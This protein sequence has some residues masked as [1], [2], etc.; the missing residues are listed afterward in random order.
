[1][2][3]KAQSARPQCWQ[4]LSPANRGIFPHQSDIGNNSRFTLRL[5]RTKGA[6]PVVCPCRSIHRKDCVST[7]ER[8]NYRCFYNKLFKNAIKSSVCAPHSGIQNF[9]VKV[10]P[11]SSISHGLWSLLCTE[12]QIH[13]HQLH[14]I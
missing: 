6:A 11:K 10:C 9:S 5:K 2:G 8:I 3:I 14:E 12:K 13:Q 4:S 7:T 1:M